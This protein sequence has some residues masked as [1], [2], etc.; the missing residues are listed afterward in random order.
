[1]PIKP[2]SNQSSEYGAPS[3][4]IGN[5]PESGPDSVRVGYETTDVNVGGVLIFL[6]GLTGFVLIFFVF[7]FVM[8]KV[9]N[10]A[11]VKE[12]GPPTKWTRNYSD[13]GMKTTDTGKR[14]NLA[15]NPDLQQKE[16]STVTRSFPSP[17]LDID[18][19][20]QA[21]ADLHAREDL[22]LNHY[23]SSQTEN[24]N[25]RIPI[26]RAMQL[27][28]QHGLPVANTNIANAGP[29]FAGDNVAVITEPLTSGFARTGYELDV[30]EARAQKL[31][32]GKAEG[33]EHAQLSPSR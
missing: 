33:T 25:L 1:M 5:K 26:D 3:G 24:G 32:Y 28:A 29:N 30:I 14:E 4:D 19:S 22:L 10:A 15:N 13:A 17:R 7:C 27:I 16:L 18:D 20:N 21:T 12:D 8:G 9:I 6:A 31:S 23:S 2:N 11:F